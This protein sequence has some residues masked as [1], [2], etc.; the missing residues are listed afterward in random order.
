VLLAIQ[1]SFPAWPAR[2]SSGA[3]YGKIRDSVSRR[4]ESFVAICRQA[5]K[6]GGQQDKLIRK[7]KDALLV[8]GARDCQILGAG[9]ACP[10]KQMLGTARPHPVSRRQH[11]KKSERPQK[12]IRKMKETFFVGKG[13]RDDFRY[14][15]LS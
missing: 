1:R 9:T 14:I 12:L 13:V 4:L 15:D 7:T 3:C 8:A 10:A 5:L 6:Q 11:F 2:E